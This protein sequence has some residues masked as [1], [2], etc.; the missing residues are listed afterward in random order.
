M[1][2][3]QQSYPLLKLFMK[4]TL[5]KG[6]ICMGAEDMKLVS[7]D[8]ETKAAVFK[9]VRDMQEGRYAEAIRGNVRILSEPFSEAVLRS[10]DAFAK[11]DLRNF[12]TE[13]EDAGCVM[14]RQVV[15]RKRMAYTWFYFREDGQLKIVF[16]MDRMLVAIF[17][18]A[19]DSDLVEC[20]F[21]AKTYWPVQQETLWLLATELGY[22]LLFEKYAK[23]ETVIAKAGKKFS[24]PELR[25]TVK[26]VLPIPVM[27]RDCT[28]FTTICRNEDFKVKGHFR[29]QPYKDEQGEWQKKLIYIN[30]F[31]KHGYHRQAK[32]EKAD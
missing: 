4:E 8:E 22:T 30:E 11:I 9:T 10:S 15:N 1:V 31:L 2:I 14:V 17:R 29:L 12:F 20:D 24:S 28:W 16:L 27:I 25:E 21:L 23:T 26:N 3:D 18:L 13:I 32:M 6:F 19:L 5:P 7:E